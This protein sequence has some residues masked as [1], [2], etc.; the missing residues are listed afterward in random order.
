MATHTHSTA[1]VHIYT[2]HTPSS[3]E[4]WHVNTP[5]PSHHL[6]IMH[7][8]SLVFPP[9]PPSQFNGHVDTF[10]CNTF[11][12]Q[13]SCQHIYTYYIHSSMVMSTHLHIQS[14]QSS[15]HVNV[16]TNITFT[17]QVFLPTHSNTTFNT[18]YTHTLLPRPQYY[19]KYQYHTLVD[20]NTFH[21][22]STLHNKIFQQLLLLEKFA[23]C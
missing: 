16:F 10:T 23:F 15:G 18:A 6:Y 1:R 9:H 4:H 22:T 3:Q 13:W 11:T 21:A 14:L 17:V 2:L 19:L 12:D 20:T 8:L 5:T 7:L